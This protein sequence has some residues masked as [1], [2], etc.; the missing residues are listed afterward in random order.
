M[1]LFA[2]IFLFG[3]LAAGCR[4]DY[5]SLG[6]APT[7]IPRDLII[8]RDNAPDRIAEIVSSSRLAANDESKFYNGRAYTF[9]KT[10]QVNELSDV[11]N[12]NETAK[13]AQESGSDA[14]V[15]A[16]GNIDEIALSNFVNQLKSIGVISVIVDYAKTP[17]ATSRVELYL[18]R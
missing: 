4:G 7:E 8:A 12:V 5:P 15:M 11:T 17:E 14:L 3:L 2:T 9:L 10:L 16:Y 18:A 13:L 6:S 1:R